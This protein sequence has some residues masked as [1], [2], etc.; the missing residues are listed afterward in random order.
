MNRSELYKVV[1]HLSEEEWDNLISVYIDLIPDGYKTE[2]E[3]TR[4]CDEYAEKFEKE[5]PG[6]HVDF[7]FYRHSI[8]SI[9]ENKGVDIN[10]L[11]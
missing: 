5:Y 4:R 11:M 1:L 3:Y 7:D 9:L 10:K 8:L 2:D 6:G